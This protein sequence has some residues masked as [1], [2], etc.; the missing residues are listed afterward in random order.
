[1]I[2]KRLSPIVVTLLLAACAGPESDAPTAAAGGDPEA[3]ATGE[4]QVLFD[5][6]GLDAFT[7]SGDA[8]WTIE[9]ATVRANTGT[10]YLV[11][12]DR[13][14]DFEL[15]AEFWVDVPANSG[16]FIR[17]AD[18]ENINATACYEVNIFDTRPDPTYRTGGIVD[19]ASPKSEMNAAG[20]WNRFV[21][22]AE[23]A[24]LR[25]DFNG[26]RTVD[27]EDSRLADG[28]IGFQ[29]GAGTVIFRNLRIRRL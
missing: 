19:V 3:A 16:I 2:V 27:V 17:C 11:T 25:V 1:M 10:G 21:I 13:F 5:G 15:E 20:R 12:N 22:A 18:A 29:Y 28:V 26:V 6:S 8:N 24:T 7:P 9:G 23:G 4:W 14:G